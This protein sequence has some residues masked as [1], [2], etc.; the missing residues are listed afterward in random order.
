MPEA[1]KMQDP[2][3]KTRSPIIATLGHVDH[4]KTTL[5]DALRG[6]SVAKKEAGGITQMIGASYLSQEDLREVSKK[7]SDR[8][9]FELKIPGLLFIDTPGHAAF[10]NLRERGGSIADLAILVI[11][12]TNGIQPQTEESIRILRQYKTPFIIAANKIDAI[13][14]WK[15]QKTESF[16][17]SLEKQQEGVKNKL[18]EKLYEIVGRL[19]EIGMESER[20]DR[21]PDFRTQVGIV[22]V[23]AKTREGIGELIMLIA[24]LTQKFLENELKIEVKGLAKS[25]ASRTKL[26]AELIGQM[27]KEVVAAASSIERTSA[28]VAEGLKFSREAGDALSKITKS[29]EISLDMAK[30]IEKAAEEQSHGVSQVVEAIQKVNSMV[31]GIKK[32]TDEQTMAS[33]EIMQATEDI[34]GV[35]QEVSHSTKEQSKQGKYISQ[36]IFDVSQ[37]MGLIANAMK[38]QKTIAEKIVYTI[39]TIKKKTNENLLLT[40]E[41][42][43]TVKNLDTQAV[44]LNEQVGGFKV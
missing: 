25:T 2:E 18:D 30:K 24:G 39:E 40:V 28:R 16:F 29:S 13:H 1:N 7:V 21:V 33:K 6:S 17:E 22:P 27:Q 37:K 26:I 43:K 42:D 41:L 3:S 38:E 11:D 4:G 31:E 12:I 15:S 35:T 5:L 34:K 14:G 23:S 36:V 32:A 10:T 19:S 9:K 20:F 44:S 8:T